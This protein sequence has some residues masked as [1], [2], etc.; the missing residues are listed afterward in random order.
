MPSYTK[1]PA[2]LQFS[3]K[4]FLIATCTAGVGLGILGRQFLNDPEMFLGVLQVL[5]TVVPFLLA[6]GTIVWLGFRGQQSCVRNY[7]DNSTVAE[8]LPQAGRRE[9][10]WDLV[11][12]GFIL[13]FMPLI[14]FGIMAVAQN[15]YGPYPG[16]LGL[17]SA[18]EVIEKHLP[19]SIDEPWVW[20]ELESR[21]QAG[22]LTKENVDAAVKKLISH[23]KTIRP[24]GWNQPLHWQTNFIKSARQ[25]GM[26]SDQVLFD[27]ADAFYGPKPVIEPLERVREGKG[28]FNIC[29]VYGSTWNDNSGLG[30]ALLWEVNRVL[31]DGKPVNIQ[32]NDIFSANWSGRYEGE[33]TAG[34][35]ELTVEVE[36]AYVEKSKMLGL[37]TSS[38][39][40]FKGRWPRAK[41]RWKVSVTTPFK[42][43]KSNVSLV[44]LDTNPINNPGPRGGVYISRFAIQTGSDGG[45]QIILYSKFNEESLST[46]LSY[47]VSV[48]LEGRKINLGV[49]WIALRPNGSYSSGGQ[50]N[51]EISKIDPT[52]NQA[53][54]ILT[55]NPRH[56]EHRPE[57]DEIWGKKVVMRGV[58][59]ERL[60]LETE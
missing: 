22:T 3:L 57:V 35:H 55:P 37:N 42:V 8:S 9:R 41:K 11:A 10:R 33:F 51:Q 14:G 25:S 50:Y 2:R 5:S 12:W 36:C 24:N 40:I 20:R 23:M 27:L 18:E 31:L 43:F 4:T 45:K 26:I 48:V 13:L 53:D 59:L 34:E 49:Q 58:P 54:I 39:G 44:K 17:L 29:L 38:T 52:T 56:I 47:D 46:S 7:G 1:K 16:R 15:L 28:G 6:V 30:L 32:F 19:K 21:L 60:D